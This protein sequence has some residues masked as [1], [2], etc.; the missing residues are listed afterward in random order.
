MLTRDDVRG[1]GDGRVNDP[2][3][4]CGRYDVCDHVRV[5]GDD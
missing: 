2:L 1:R 3:C 4:V 5:Y